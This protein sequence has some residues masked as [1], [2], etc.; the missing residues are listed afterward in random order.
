MNKAKVHEIAKKMGVNSKEVIEKATE[1][2]IDAKTHLSI[3]DESDAKR[4][5]DKILE[6]KKETGEKKS[7]PVIIRREVIMADHEVVQKRETVKKEEPRKE[8]GF[9]ERDRKR[10]YNIVYRNKPTKP[11]TVNELF[12]KKEEPK[13]SPDSVQTPIENNQPSTPKEERRRQ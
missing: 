7:G 1:L 13:K 8:V 3:I 10:D 9:V 11:L 5:E 6:G 4:I 2:G 12:G